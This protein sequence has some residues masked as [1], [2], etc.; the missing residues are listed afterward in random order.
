MSDPIVVTN[1]NDGIDVKSDPAAISEGG[2]ADC[3]GFDLTKEGVLN[4]AGG[5]ASHDLIGLLPTGS[6]QWV[7]I[8]YMGGTKYVLATTLTGLYANG[9]LVSSTFVG[10]FRGV[11]FLSN[12]YLMNGAYALRFDGTTCYQWGITAPLVMPTITAAAYLSTTIDTFESL[13]T[14]TANQ[15]SCVVS[16]E[17]VLFKEG[18]QSAH[19]AVAASTTGYS[20]VSGVIDGTLFSSGHD[21]SDSDYVR[22]WLY[23]TDYNNL[24]SITIYFDTGDGTFVNDYFSYTIV[25]PDTVGNT[26]VLGF[27]STTDIITEDTVGSQYPEDLSPVTQYWDPKLGW[28]ENEPAY[29]TKTRTITI[30]KVTRKAVVPSVVNDQTLTFWQKSDLFQVKNATWKE[31]KIPK[32]LFLQHG[33]VGK[34]WA[35]IVARKIEVV[36]NANGI[37]NAYFDGMKF[38]GGSDLVGDYWFMYSWGRMDSDSNVLHQSAPSRNDA[39]KQFNVYGPVAFDRHPLTYASRPLSTDPQVNCAVLSAIGGSLADFWEIATIE[40]N[41]TATDT[42]YNIGDKHATRQITNKHN[43]PAPPGR[44]LVLFRNKIWMVDDPSYPGVL[45]SSDIL[46][47]GTI[48]PESWPTRNA[49]EMAESEGALLSVRVVNKQLVVKGEM[50][51]WLVKVLDP[52]DYLQVGADRVSSM[53]LLGRDAII[54]METSNIYPSQN[55]FIE[56]DGNMAKIVLPE[57]QPLIDSNITSAKGV[58]AGL[59][60][61]FSYTTDAYG[62][63]TA[64]IDLLRGK[65][66]I[67]NLVNIAFDCLEHDKKANKVYGVINGAVY[68]LDSGSINAAIPENEVYCYLKSRVYRRGGKVSWH[69]M[70]VLHNTGGVWFRLEI[71]L[72]DVLINS[73]PF[74]STSKTRSSF[75]FGPRS[76]YDFQFRIVGDTTQPGTIH[77]PMRIR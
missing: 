72:D 19:F 20:Y 59:I 27:G 36:S 68:I 35:D 10:R 53:G 5:L 41:T 30:N 3:I 52:T 2:L 61:Y 76:G 24:D 14:W 56:S 43:E 9:V 16:A 70:E 66:R 33:S 71:Y 51:E 45:R 63:R 38:V 8:Y 65:A 42:L 11:V 18:T 28:V 57:V 29:R 17:V 75:T 46:L 26:Q 25:A 74:T 44:G 37:A 15:V 34:T 7:Q 23:V 58:N 69:R 32:N 13:A 22:F 77:F 47:D 64:K 49:Y 67:T 31:F 54:D 40:D 21:S 4:T 12:I 50:G 73:F 48:S 6:I 39:T 55:G 60:S 1:L 62:P